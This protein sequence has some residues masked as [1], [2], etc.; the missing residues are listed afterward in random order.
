MTVFSNGVPIECSVSSNS[1]SRKLGRETLYRQERRIRS[2]FPVIQLLGSLE[3][4]LDLTVFQGI[5]VSSNSASRKLGSFKLDVWY[6]VVSLF[7]V[8]QLLGSLEE[9]QIKKRFAAP[10]GFQ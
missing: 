9:L 7:P 8:I 4:K 5:F 10:Y 6:Q 2:E 3:V 1:A